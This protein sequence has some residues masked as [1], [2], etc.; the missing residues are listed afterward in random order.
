VIPLLI[1]SLTF[2]LCFAAG[3]ALVSVYPFYDLVKTIGGKRY[4]VG[5]LIPP[6]ADYHLYELTAGDLLRLSRAEIL[7]VS[8]IPLGGWEEKAEELFR[9]R[10]VRLTEG[11]DLLPAAGHAPDHGF[12]GSDPHVWLSP[13]TMIDVARS[14]LAGFTG[15]DPEGK[16]LYRKGFEIL[17]KR[18]AALDDDYRE[19]LRSCRYRVLP[20]VHPALGYL[21]RDYG[22][23]QIFLSGADV[24]GDISPGELSRFVKELRHR[25]IP[26]VFTIR[27]ERSKLAELLREEYGLRLFELN[28][29]IVPDEDTPDYFAIMRANLRTLREALQCR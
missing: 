19:A 27:G 10:V 4:E 12:K 21:A 23:T 8:G 6:R 17:R 28:V 25:H 16:E 24:H 1:L 13:R 22:F 20:V 18:L 7:F 3:E 11:V 26:F 9:G 5:V 15:A 29:K 14:A 2:S